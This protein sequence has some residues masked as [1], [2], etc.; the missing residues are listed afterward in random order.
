MQKPDL[1]EERFV[2]FDT[3]LRRKSRFR[4]YIL[5]V[6]GKLRRFFQFWGKSDRSFYLRLLMPGD[7]NLFLP[8]IGA[9]LPL[10]D[11]SQGKISFH[12]SGKVHYKH[13]RNGTRIDLRPRSNAP[14][15]RERLV[16]ISLRELSN[17]PAADHDEFNRAKKQALHVPFVEVPGIPFMLTVYR[18]N[19]P[20]D[21]S[22]PPLGDTFSIRS[23]LRVRDT[24]CAFWIVSWQLKASR[25]WPNF[26][27]LSFDIPDEVD[28]YAEQYG[29]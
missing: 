7:F 14:R 19:E 16:T 13:D 17:L 15:A 1:W 25:D 20:S 29:V 28:N 11:M 27:P 4:T 24:K 6:D 2:R 10:P 22:P 5:T 18:V 21:W 9:R 8:R 23:K 12:G 3:T 26:G